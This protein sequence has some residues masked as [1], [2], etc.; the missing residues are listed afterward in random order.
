VQSIQH[1]YRRFS[2]GADGTR[3]RDLRRA[4]ALGQVLRYVVGFHYL[5]QIRGKAKSLYRPIP[6]RAVRVR[7][8]VR[9]KSCLSYD[10]YVPSIGKPAS[11]SLR[12]CASWM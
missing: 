5:L 9:V 2:S 7:V 3:T 8:M 1:I 6:L 12:R 10:S 11:T 4:K